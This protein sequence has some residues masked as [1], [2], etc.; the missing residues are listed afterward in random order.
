MPK[1]NPTC[2]HEITDYSSI[3]G[4]IVPL[5]EV[6]E[7]C[8]NFKVLEKITFVPGW[9]HESLPDLEIKQIAVL[10]LDNDYYESTL[11]TIRKFYPLVPIGG[12][13]IVDDYDCV[14]G[15]K[16]AIDQFREESHIKDQMYRMNKSM[17][18]GIYW[19]KLV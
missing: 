8:S 18:T 3:T 5:S 19:Q 17:N 9:F 6:R 11:M 4:L 1:P 12:W 14:P 10:R 2:P 15:A 16:T 7:A 13:I